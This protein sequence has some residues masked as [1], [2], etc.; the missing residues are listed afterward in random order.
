MSAD[1]FRAARPIA[2]AL[3]IAVSGCVR[4]LSPYDKMADKKLSSAAETLLDL[5][6]ETQLNP[7]PLIN[8]EVLQARGVELRTDIRVA[9]N[10]YEGSYGSSINEGHRQLVVSSI[11]SC[12][13]AV[14]AFFE[15]LARQGSISDPAT[16]LMLN[17]AHATCL[18]ATERVQDG[19]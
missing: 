18:T 15:F 19:K 2:L 9:R 13:N 7:Q 10:M 17:N 16:N 3:C 4:V 8:S 1:H 14:R 11:D 6:A 5:Q 12:D